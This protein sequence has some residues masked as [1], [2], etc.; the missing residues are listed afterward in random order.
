MVRPASQPFRCSNSKIQR[1]LYIYTILQTSIHLSIRINSLSIRINSLSIRINSHFDTH[2]FTFRYAS[3]LLFDHLGKAGY[4]IVAIAPA[5]EKVEIK[6]DT[7]HFHSRDFGPRITFLQVHSQYR[8]AKTPRRPA[9]ARSRTWQR[10]F[11][12]PWQCPGGFS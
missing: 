9:E 8:P 6:S 10:G 2:Q 7:W 5:P 11:F 1:I 4:K 12:L 3:V